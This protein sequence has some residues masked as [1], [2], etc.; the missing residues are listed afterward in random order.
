MKTGIDSVTRT[1][2]LAA[3][4]ACATAFADTSAAAVK[5]AFVFNFAK[6]VE[7]PATA[8][9]TPQSPLE[10]CVSG[11]TFEGRLQQLEGREAQGH[12]IH[13]RSVAGIDALHGCH[14]LVLGDQTG[15][16]RN[17]LLQS[18]GRGPVLTIRDNADFTR[19]G[20]MIAL[21]V[22]ANRVQFSVNLGAAQG[23]G[24]KL[25]ARMLNLAHSVQGG[26]P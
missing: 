5:A 8:F 12:P 19:E 26:A 15:V 7:W 18:A 21:F 3:L 10:L 6:F 2:G 25:S 9:A 23:V 13:V 4:L 24:L 1:L 11:P 20:G 22:A 14:I 17:L 16:D